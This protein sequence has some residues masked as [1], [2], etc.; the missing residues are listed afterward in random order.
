MPKLQKPSGQDQTASQSKPYVARTTCPGDFN[1]C[2]VFKVQAVLS[3]NMWVITFCI[4]TWIWTNFSPFHQKCKKCLFRD[5]YLGRPYAGRG[6]RSFAR[7]PTVAAGQNV[8]AALAPE[9]W[10]QGCRDIDRR[11]RS[12][13]AQMTGHR[14]TVGHGATVGHRPH[15]RRGAVFGTFKKKFQIFSLKTAC[16]LKISF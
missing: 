1:C 3:R 12:A 4:S 10:R 2:K 13:I 15:G 14:P 5:F 11:P 8:A 7:W 9:L 16:T 6:G